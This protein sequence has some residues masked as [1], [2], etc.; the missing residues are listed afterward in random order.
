MRFP[1]IC[2]G[3]A[4]AL[5]LGCRSRAGSPAGGSA[6]AAREM[7]SGDSMKAHALVLAS[8]EFQG[9][10]PGTH[11]DTL[12]T[13]Y[14]AA[15]FERI[16]L[17][18]GMPDGSFRQMVPFWNGAAQWNVTL[19]SHG[20]KVTLDDSTTS[21]SWESP[22]STEVNLA[23]KALVFAGYGIDAPE[24]EW[25]DYKTPVA[26][27]IVVVLYGEPGRPD[28]ANPA[29]PDTTFFLGDELGWYGF[30]PHKL[31]A[32]AAAGAEA[33][34][35]VVDE[36]T[37]GIPWSALQSY[38]R[39]RSHLMA[40]PRYP[41]QAQNAFFINRGAAEKL[42]ALAG[43]KYD[44]LVKAANQ[45]NFSP[46]TLPG[47]A[48]IHLKQ[49][50]REF[51]SANVV[52][53]IP[54]SD[55]VLKGQ[56]VVYSAH[57]DHM[58]I[59]T[60]R[61]GD[62]IYNG[63]IDNA[64]GVAALLELARAF[65]ATPTPPR[66]TVIFVATT[67]EEQLLLGAQYYVYHPIVPLDST[68]ADLDIDGVNAL[69]RAT[70]VSVMG[71]EETTLGD[72][73]A[74]VARAR[75]RTMVPNPMLVAGGRYRTDRFAFARGGVPAIILQGA[76]LVGKTPE[77]EA[78]LSLDYLVNRY[79]QVTDTLRADQDFSGAEDDVRLLFDLGSR[80]ADG[81]PRPQWKGGL[82]HSL[83]FGR[84]VAVR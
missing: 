25:K 51:G 81:A 29:R 15:A 65:K 26:G 64:V 67:A 11:G 2:L 35:L 22:P 18:P 20:K 79:H 83:M 84:P 77:E 3:C 30:I 47:T 73:L 10:A 50:I 28:P 5:A 13:A 54:G 6:D 57:W 46:V 39:E 4:A 38:S 12:A 1:L 44:D 24:V 41:K 56:A 82:R 75:S 31:E 42:I 55:P 23:G 9:R 8:D 48:S 72:M 45:K 21:I 19:E 70:A 16:G 76:G 36:K 58:G 14:I 78:K 34:L 59:D 62:Q 27:K 49:R 52:G 69:G 43:L 68:I 33:V 40:D 37:S 53:M 7:I 17:K 32:A 80:L 66:R 74:E 63:G 60:T 71:A 61:K